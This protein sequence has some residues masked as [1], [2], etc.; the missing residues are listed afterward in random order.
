MVASL[1]DRVY[2]MAGGRLLTKGTFDDVTRDRGVLE[3]YLGVKA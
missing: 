1:C 3:A 2:V